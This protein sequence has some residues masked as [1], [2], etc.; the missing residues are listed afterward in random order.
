MSRSQLDTNGDG[1]GGA[2]DWWI[3]G[4]HLPS[5]K[6]ERGNGAARKMAIGCSDRNGQ[7][8]DG[9]RWEPVWH[10]MSRMRHGC[11]ETEGHSVGWC[12]IYVFRYSRFPHRH[13]ITD[14]S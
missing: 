9:Q 5:L 13:I 10:D 14:R 8:P 2:S 11:F 7:C 4:R 12:V 3:A 6:E 1:C